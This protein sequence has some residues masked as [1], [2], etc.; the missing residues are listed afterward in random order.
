MTKKKQ[1][2]QKL[3]DEIRAK[4]KVA[5]AM[6]KADANNSTL[7]SRADEEET[8]LLKA[9]DDENWRVRENAA[10]NPNASEAVLRKAVENKDASVRKKAAGNAN[11]CARGI[12]EAQDKEVQLT[13][14]SLF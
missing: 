9:L 13:L 12:K 4:A 7:A 10:A 11:E 3:P 8:E 1:K 2:Q 6:Y 14:F 5:L